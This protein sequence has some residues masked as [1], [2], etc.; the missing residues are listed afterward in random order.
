MMG[1]HTLML[2]KTLSSTSQ[3]N[4]LILQQVTMMLME[5]RSTKDSKKFCLIHSV[6]LEDLRDKMTQWMN[7]A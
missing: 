7:L 3:S 2:R 4:S 6:S 1:K 5:L